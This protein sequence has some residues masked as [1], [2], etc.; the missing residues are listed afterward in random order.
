MTNM[1]KQLDI[2]VDR[3]RQWQQDLMAAKKTGTLNM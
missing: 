2:P 3:H 1:R